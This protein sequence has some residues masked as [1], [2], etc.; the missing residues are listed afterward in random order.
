M[1]KGPLT[2]TLSSASGII[3]AIG[4]VIF[5]ISVVSALLTLSTE[6]LVDVAI[7]RL[8]SSVAIGGIFALLMGMCAAIE[9]AF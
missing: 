3:G 2:S 8:V 5:T 7:N 6:G 4:G 9:N 1:T